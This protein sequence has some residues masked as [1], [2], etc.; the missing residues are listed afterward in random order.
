MIEDALRRLC[1]V[2]ILP[3][4]FTR[5]LNGHTSPLRFG[6]FCGARGGESGTFPD[7]GDPFQ[8]GEIIRYTWT[9]RRTD[10]EPV[11]LNFPLLFGP[12]FHGGPVDAFKK[13]GYVVRP[14]QSIV[15]HERMFVDPEIDE[16][17]CG[18]ILVEEDGF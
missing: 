11:A 14:F 2:P 15:N 12:C 17:V 7:G 1:P 3:P 16:P 4:L 13:C 8:T 9:F 6:R 5:Y 18:V 10:R